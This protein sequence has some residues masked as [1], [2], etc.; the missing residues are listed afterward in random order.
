MPF[1]K[2]RV[3]GGG[4]TFNSDNGGTS[5]NNWQEVYAQVKTDVLFSGLLDLIGSQPAPMY[6]VDIF[7]TQTG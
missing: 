4:G 7:L 2:K 3:T 1:Y 5:S 6:A